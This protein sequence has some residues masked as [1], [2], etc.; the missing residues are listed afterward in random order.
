MNTKNTWV[1]RLLADR[2][3]TTRG[4]SARRNPVAQARPLEGQTFLPFAQ[5]PKST[6]GSYQIIGEDEAPLGDAMPTNL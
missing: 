3:P 2:P 6:K 1:V 4:M 5:S